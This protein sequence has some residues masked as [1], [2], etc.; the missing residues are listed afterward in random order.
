MTEQS[1][2]LI[3][4]KDLNKNSW[5]V[6]F[7][8][9]LDSFSLKEKRKEILDLVE[10]F[11]RKYLVFDF[12]KLN[13]INSESIGL[14]MQISEILKLK[15]KQL[16]VVEAKKNVIDVL[17]VIGVFEE[18]RHFKLKSDFLRSLENVN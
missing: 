1:L 8:G 11:D 9:N 14:L 15:D 7:S 10:S 4:D 13:F 16:V 5:I 6:N 3:V 18:I 12:M 17:N 2:N